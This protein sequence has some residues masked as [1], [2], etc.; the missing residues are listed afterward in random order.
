MA[1]FGAVFPVLPGKSDRVKEIGA[2]LMGEH[3]EAFAASQQQL[4][5]PVESWHLQ[6]TPMGDFLVVYLESADALQMFQD[7]AKAQGPSDVFLKD[8]ILEC[9]GFDLNQ[10]MPGLPSVPVLDYRA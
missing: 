4:G 3:A 5:V 6:Q 9:T 10:P 8:G 2:A 7:F 1:V